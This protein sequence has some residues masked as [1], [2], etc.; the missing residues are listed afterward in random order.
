MAQTLLLKYT[1]L[2]LVAVAPGVLAG[3]RAVLRYVY[4]AWLLV[5]GSCLYVIQHFLAPYERWDE[6][7]HPDTKRFL[8]VYRLRADMDRRFDA[9]LRGP[10]IVPVS[11]LGTIKPLVNTLLADSA[12]VFAIAIVALVCLPPAHACA[13]R[14]LRLASWL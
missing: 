8:S 5:A 3:L 12:R 1:F 10:H 14:L 6:Q 7:D 11:E 4:E 9:L 13:I 2:G